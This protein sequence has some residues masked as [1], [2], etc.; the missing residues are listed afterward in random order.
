MCKE[1]NEVDIEALS[2]AL[3][4]LGKTTQELIEQ[5]Q[6]ATIELVNIVVKA[7]NDIVE[8]CKEAQQNLIIDLDEIEIKGKAKNRVPFYKGLFNDSN[9]KYN[10][11]LKI[12]Q[13]VNM[14]PVAIRKNYI[15]YKRLKIP[16]K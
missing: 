4:E 1:N 9:I 5:F 16:V 6:N 8:A 12:N 10:M 11:N 14:K 3:Y 2:E 15:K 7:N 13:C